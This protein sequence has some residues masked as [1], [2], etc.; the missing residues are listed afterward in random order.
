MVY[1]Q[2]GDSEL[3]FDYYRQALPIRRATGNLSGVATTMNNLAS[4]HLSVGEYSQAKQYLEQG[5]A[6]Y[7]ELGDAVGMSNIFNELG[8]LA[9][10][11]AFYRQALEYY[12]SSLNV[13]MDANNQMLQAESMNN[14]GFAYFM[15][16]DPEH[17]LVY[18]RQAEQMFQS[19][20][21]PIGIVRV[22][23]SIGQ[24]EL[25]KGNWRN[26]F[27]I[28]Q[29]SKR[30]AQALNSTEERF[31]ATSYLARLSF[32]QG[33]FAASLETLRG[34]YTEAKQ[35]RDLRAMSEFGLWIADWSLQ[36]GDVTSA[37]AMLEEIRPI[38]DKS[39][40]QDAKSFLSY[41]TASGLGQFE[42]TVASQLQE[43]DFGHSYIEIRRD[44][45]LAKHK[46]QRGGQ[47]IRAELMRLANLDYDLFQFERLEV[48]ELQ[49]VQAYFAKDWSGLKHHLRQA[50]LLMRKM[51]DP[52]RSFQFDRLRAQLA[53]HS[54]QNSQVYLDKAKAKLQTLLNN[55]P[56]E[57]STSFIQRQ[58][59]FSLDD[60][61]QDTNQH[62]Q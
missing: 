42:W 4:V 59:Y 26:A 62:E 57:Q 55:L 28:F 15:L 1:E 20:Q 54:G 21:F 9:E 41:L 2:L 11:Q 51:G 17:A 40:S 48:L 44:I 32:L 30:D 52:W 37:Q 34:V 39:G 19:I 49:A 60:G 38:I 16:L 47:D 27:H 53:K 13:R 3:A 10:E 33:N 7:Q 56:L 43:Q 50:E 25:A 58:T 5:L 45:A 23:Q 24:L 8:V 61:I 31:V 6:V 22:Q 36:I 35:N 29:N 18:W 14:V 12:R 46:L